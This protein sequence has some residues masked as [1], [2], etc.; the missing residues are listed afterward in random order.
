MGFYESLQSLDNLAAKMVKDL[1][2]LLSLR[3]TSPTFGQLER[4]EACCHMT[5]IIH[6]A[7]EIDRNFR[8][9]KDLFQV[10]MSLSPRSIDTLLPCPYNPTWVMDCNDLDLWFPGTGVVYLFVSPGLCV[11][12]ETDRY[13]DANVVARLEAFCNLPMV[14]ERLRNPQE[15]VVK[16]DPSSEESSD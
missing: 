2:P 9:S 4:E 3:F 15:W 12:G 7:G 8:L 5:Q 1:E 11:Y 13:Y 10:Y 16:E 14:L 6:K